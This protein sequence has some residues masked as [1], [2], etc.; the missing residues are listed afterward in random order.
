MNTIKLHAHQKS[1]KKIS[2]LYVIDGFP[3][4][5]DS[6][7]TLVEPGYEFNYPIPETRGNAASYL[8][9]ILWGNNLYDIQILE[10]WYYLERVQN[11]ELD[12]RYND[13]INYWLLWVCCEDRNPHKR[14]IDMPVAY[15]NATGIGF[16]QAAIHLLIRAWEQEVS[17]FD[18]HTKKVFKGVYEEGALSASQ[19]ILAAEQVWDDVDG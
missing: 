7:I 5:P 4:E 8:F 1:L 3:P 6:K 2:S 18:L 17:D 12:W 15:L 9:S 10:R 14:Y 13:C 16:E 19:I 11:Q